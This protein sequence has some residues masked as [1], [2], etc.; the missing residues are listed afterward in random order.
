MAQ[1]DTGAGWGTDAGSEPSGGLETPT[2]EDK[3]FSLTKV[4]GSNN[5]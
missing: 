5:R 4:R 3:F 2:E 1:E